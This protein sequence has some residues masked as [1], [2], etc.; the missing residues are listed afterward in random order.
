MTTGDPPDQGAQV[1]PIW[2]QEE[3]IGSLARFVSRG[4]LRAHDLTPTV[5]PSPDDAEVAAELYRK[6]AALGLRGWEE[7]DLWQDGQVVRDPTWLLAKGGN[8]M[9]LSTTYAAMC[10]QMG[11]SPLIALTQTHAFVVLC[12]GR[13]KDPERDPEML[14]PAAFAIE[15]AEAVERGVVEVRDPEA[16]VAAIRARELL[17]VDCIKATDGDASFARAMDSGA[18]RVEAGLLLVDVLWLQSF[19]GV[20]ELPPADGWTAVRRHLPGG[21]D[22]VPLFDSQRELVDRLSTMTGTVAILG[23]SGLGKSTVARRLAQQAPNGSGWFVTASDTQSLIDGLA[24]AELAHQG[25]TGKGLERPDREAL[26]QAAFG[27]LRDSAHPWIVVLD[28][29]DGDP[30]KLSRF[31][32]RPG[33]PHYRQLVVVTTTNPDWERPNVVVHRL[34]PAT[35]EEIRERLGTDRLTDLIDGRALLI[36][37]FSRLIEARPEAVGDVEPGGADAGPR[38]Y[39]R[40]LRGTGVPLPLCALAALMPPDHLPVERL[41]A[42]AGA[43]GDVEELARRGLFALDAR[44]SRARLHRL[45]GA[46]MRDDIE[47]ELLDV[48]ALVLSADEQ[49]LELMNRSAEL[50]LVELVLARLERLDDANAVAPEG[51]TDAL[52]GVGRML[53]MRGNTVRSADAYGRLRKRLDP[54]NPAHRLAYAECLHAG[55]RVAYRNSKQEEPLRA[56]LQDAERAYELADGSASAG[57]YLAMR[58]LILKELAAFPKPGETKAQLLREAV[59]VLEE[60]DALRAQ[61]LEPDH[62]ERIRSRFNLAGVRLPLAQAEPQAAAGHLTVA[63]E[64]YA[65]VAARRERVFGV[66]VHPQIAPCIQGRG[67]VAY[68]RALLVADGSVERSRYL[69]EAT[70]HVGDA[71]AQWQQIEDGQDAAECQKATGYLAKIAL[72]RHAHQLAAK[73]ELDAVEGRLTG[74][75]ARVAQEMRGEF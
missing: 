63:D 35:P 25:V 31:L 69:R 49:M 5:R 37:A 23:E 36:D 22:D 66:P 56:A 12:P 34:S 16:L 39:W 27:R 7:P 60:A 46:A 18:D 58:G 8:C 74:V 40:A 43:P 2:K 51:L 30:A 32:P 42:L 17:A 10:L 57:P 73:G 15:G 28:N 20:A 72:A 61:R 71:L 33:P 11:V 14:D 53:E 24:E 21:V 64:I 55:A 26:A 54:A 52:R 68:Y 38:A 75:A 29:A 4:A 13:V 1:W 59:T 47:P 3:G 70:A 6:L 62:L 45:L 9:D 19:G 65:E 67:L 41:E 48:A 50:S 44:G